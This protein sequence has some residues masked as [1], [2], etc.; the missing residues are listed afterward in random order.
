MIYTLSCGAEDSSGDVCYDSAGPF[1]PQILP[2]PLKSPPKPTRKRKRSNGCGVT[3]HY[4]AIVSSDNMWR[5]GE[6]SRGHIVPL[7]DIYFTEDVRERLGLGEKSC[8]RCVREGVGCRTC[9]NALGVLFT[10]CD[11]HQESKSGQNY[12]SIL[13]S[14]V[15][16]PIPPYVPLPPPP[17]V[18]RHYVG[19]PLSWTRRRH[20]TSPPPVILY[21]DFTPTPSPEIPPTT[22]GLSGLAELTEI[23]EPIDDTRGDATAPSHAR[24][25]PSSGMRHRNADQS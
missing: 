25:A 15:S 18:I 14:A 20:P 21:A 24:E 22:F 10:P 9:G 12:Y 2:I 4:G 5:A 7:D 17:P 6:M 1:Q 23:W 8:D 3:L 11:E 13:P 16:P 19:P